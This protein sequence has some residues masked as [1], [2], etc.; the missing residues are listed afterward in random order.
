VRLSLLSSAVVG[1]SV[2]VRSAG[3]VKLSSR[4]DIGDG[5]SEVWF[6][7]LSAE[8]NLQIRVM[9]NTWT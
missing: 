4:Q 6:V 5:R 8:S 3:A 9:E 1:V 7:A 2:L